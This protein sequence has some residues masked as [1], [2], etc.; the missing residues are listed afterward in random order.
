MARPTKYK[1][2]YNN[3]AYK[4]CLLKA[5][6]KDLADFFEVHEDTINEW[7]KVHPKFSESIKKGKIQADAEVAKKLFQR[8]CGY[9]HKEDK[10]FCNAQGK[11]TTVKVTK[12]YPP[13]TAAAFIWLKNRAGW[14]DKQ[15]LVVDDKT[16]EDKLEVQDI[17]K[18]LAGLEGAGNGLTEERELK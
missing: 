16:E 10:V 14:R 2:A 18:R 11:V 7:K 12:H 8:A 17:K 3:Q 4:I 1:P 15:E 5:T 9:E 13:D 6:D